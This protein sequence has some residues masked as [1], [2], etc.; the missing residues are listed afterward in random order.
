MTH[1]FSFFRAGGFNQVRLATGADLLNLDQLDQKLWV[2]L[3]CPTRGLAFDSR[4]L[5]L[6][7]ADGDG[8]IRATELI[9]AIKWAGPLL[10][11]PEILI[12][13]PSA[14][15]LAAVNQESEAGRVLFRGAT[16]AL[17]GLGKEN[18]DSISVLD[19][20][21]ALAAFNSLPFNG[22][23]IITADACEQDEQKQLVAEV[24]ATMENRLDSS[25]RPG[26][27]EATVAAFFAAVRE[28]LAWYDK[29]TADAALL[30]LQDNTPAAFAALKQVRDKV[31]DYFVRVKLA[32]FDQRAIEALNREEKEYYALAAKDLRLSNADIRS[33]PLAK[34]EAQGELPLQQGF[35]PAWQ[36]AM[37]VFYDTVVQPLL[38]AVEHLEE[39]AWLALQARF[40]A[41]EAWE[42]SKPGMT[43][44]TLG[45]ER[46]RALA[47]PS[48]EQI[49][50]PLFAREAEEAGTA[51]GIAG[52]ERLVRYVRDLHRLCCNFVNFSQFY[53]QAEPAIFQIGTL[54]LDRRSTTLCLNVDD[55]ARHAS[56]APLSRAF[57]AYCD[58]TR[59]S[60]GEKMTIAAA[61]TNGD[62]DYLM[63]GRNGIFYDREGRDWDATVTRLVENPLSVREAFWSP[64][65]KLL[66][67][68]E[69]QVAKRAAASE[70]A[71]DAR[72]TTAAGKAGTAATSGA[73][74]AEGPKKLDIGIVAALG[75][76][77]GGITAA[78]G[79]L[80]QTFFG[81][82]IWM[83][84]GL[85]GLVLV[86]SG[87]SMLVAWLKLRQRNLGP[88][89]DANGWA[90]NASARI[91]V[92]FGE[93]LTRVA[94]LPKGAR[95]DMVDPYAD[96]RP[97]WPALT[98]LL[99]ILLL[100]WYLVIPAVN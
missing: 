27:D 87:P 69:E 59:K 83:P 1:S 28:F 70:A 84:L 81:L 92:P 2:A 33:L 23:G 42:A 36:G 14:L 34:V 38:G 73:V 19:A 62:A 43:V 56:M 32:N 20:E 10:L 45:L 100:V 35:N 91:N 31:D 44:E 25:G 63:V 52:V 49:L 75:V 46:L 26:V 6:I 12:S 65:K 96:K 8:R 86:V 55:A 82:G 37:Q 97:A 80:L 39:S 64:Y 98:G 47:N 16:L 67:F 53:R 77:V 93:S 4:T 29:G 40:A 78:L 68:I 5:A 54:Y 30:P 66:R 72:L 76:A 85:L 90:L 99:L 21:S 3:A 48:M 61:M 13:A 11:D 58:C 18:S 51:A 95:L 94:A 7:D 15:P 74:E 89:L 50:S 17:K 57:L 22:D 79:M 88:I 41:F 71:A 9:A 60:S 24:L